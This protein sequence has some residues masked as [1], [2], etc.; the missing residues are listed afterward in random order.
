MGPPPFEFDAMLM[1]GWVADTNL[2]VRQVNASL[3]SWLVEFQ[4]GVREAIQTET[5]LPIAAFFAGVLRLPDAVSEA[6]L[7]R[8]EKVKQLVLLPS[9]PVDEPYIDQSVEVKYE[10]REINHS[11][12]FGIRA[13]DVGG[14]PMRSTDVQDRVD[15]I[16]VCHTK[17]VDGRWCVT[18]YQGQLQSAWLRVQKIVREGTK[19]GAVA[20]MGR[21]LSHNIGSHAL[22]WLEQDIDS[23]IDKPT[24]RFYRY[25]RERMELLAGFAT[26][27]PLSPRTLNFSTL[28]RGF[29]ENTVFTTRLC[30]S[31]GVT[32]IKV[33]TRPGDVSRKVAIPGGNVGIQAF[34]SILENIIRDN[35]KYGPHSGEM[36]VKV[37]L[38]EIPG[39]LQD[40]YFKVTVTD[41]G[42]TAS[43]DSLKGLQGTLNNLRIADEDGYLKEGFWGVK[44][45]FIA[46]ALL[47]GMRVEDID[48]VE[49]DKDGQPSRW[50]LNR[51]QVGEPPILAV[52]TVGNSLAWEFYLLKAKEVIVAGERIELA[53]DLQGQVNLCSMEWF[54]ENIRRASAIRHRFVLL[55][56][57]VPEDLAWI[58]HHQ[59]NFPF[60]TFI[61]GRL[62]KNPTIG[63]PQFACLGDGAL[64]S[65]R[66]DA[67]DLYEHW[68]RAL[69]PH[70]ENRYILIKNSR[71]EWKL[72]WK[73]EVPE[74]VE[75]LDEVHKCFSDKDCLGFIDR[76]WK[77]Y[78]EWLPDHAFHY[79]VDDGTNMLRP[80]LQTWPPLRST[81][82]ALFE[83]ALI[84]VL[85]I[86]EREDAVSERQV[87]DEDLSETGKQCTIKRRFS[88]KGITIHGSEYSGEAI[89][90]KT[91][92][93]DWATEH[94]PHYYHFICIHRGILD[95]LDKVHGQRTANVCAE[96]RKVTPNLIVHSGRVGATGLPEALKFVPLSNVTAWVDGGRGK[97]EIVDELCLIRRT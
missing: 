67:G 73:S 82:H 5:G 56:P 43:P 62:C 96:L 11:L 3:D 95:K 36:A 88:M 74:R 70:L 9:I 18:G 64:D 6:L 46:A 27:M 71:G 52:T 28:I 21:N 83:A 20:L 80:L 17:K 39:E 50:N 54:K 79:E 69:D 78:E 15:L 59:A 91:K 1:Y 32:I 51:T 23:K 13:V 4:P 19:S 55:V 41:D 68:L 8:L 57:D 97:M 65:G 29:T 75:D 85:L 60:R 94:G 37:D 38:D 48:P 72:R 34:Y 45:R 22:F 92:L 63:A 33:K 25:L 12:L 53:A 90:D 49:R 47:R 81:T 31:E 7:S 93:V 76:H 26:S 61:G 14:F 87:S 10:F 89:P 2:M 84:K 35:A 16:S 58:T 40:E 30:K 42:G 44:E 86:D 66:L 24:S 77:H